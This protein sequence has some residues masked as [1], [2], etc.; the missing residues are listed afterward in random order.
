[1]RNRSIL[2]AGAVL[3]SLAVAASAARAASITYDIRADGIK[4]VSSAGVPNGDPDGRAIGTVRLDNGTGSG[5]TGFAVINLAVTNV[6]G[7]LSGHHIHQAGPTTTGPIVVDFGNPA[8]ILTGT[9]QNGTLSG[10]I[11]NLPAATISNV[12][13]NPTG[14]YYNLHSQPSFAS[15]AVRDQLPE[16]G[17]AALV[18][19]GA[20]GL[21]ARKRRRA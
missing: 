3:V 7:T 14:F 1:M 10:T 11:S 6:D 21:L 8:T 5:N 17:T 9:G 16:P 15:G 4:E 2:A 19:L 18:A 12:F 13:A 20:L